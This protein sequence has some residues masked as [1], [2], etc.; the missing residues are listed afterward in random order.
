MSL[1]L[2]LS[3]T[4][5]DFPRKQEV[6]EADLLVSGQFYVHF[7]ELALLS[8]SLLFL[9]SSSLSFRS[10][11]QDFCPSH[12]LE[13]SFLFHSIKINITSPQLPPETF[14]S[15]Y[16]QSILLSLL[17]ECH[18]HQFLL[19]KLPQSYSLST[20]HPSLED[21]AIFMLP[22]GNHRLWRH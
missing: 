17:W 13:D 6:Q 21:L 1:S 7:W 11:W 4:L 18:N 5:S 14:T 12:V 15:F 19:C 9:S 16:S 10:L 20:K 22:L 3:F 8:P 2:F